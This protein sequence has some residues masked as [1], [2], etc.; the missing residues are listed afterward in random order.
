VSIGVIEIKGLKK[1]KQSLIQPLIQPCL[2]A[3][4]FGSLSACLQDSVERMQ[5]L[6]IFK[7]INV[8][9]DRLKDVTAAG[10]DVMVVIEAEEKKYRVHAGTEMKRNDIAFVCTVLMLLNSYVSLELEWAAV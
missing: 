7:G 9:L 3:T 1:T 8:T 10:H 5:R 4:T 6:D 2:T